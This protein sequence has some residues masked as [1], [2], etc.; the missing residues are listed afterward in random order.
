[1]LYHILPYRLLHI[2]Y[3]LFHLRHC[4]C[5]FQLRKYPL[6]VQ[7]L[8]LSVLLSILSSSTLV[9]V[10]FGCTTSSSPYHTKT[11]VKAHS[12]D[13]NGRSQDKHASNVIYNHFSFDNIY[14]PQGNNICS[15]SSA[16]VFLFS[17]I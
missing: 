8:N 15:A 13:C 4:H 12:E 9:F 5:H 16:V 3:F 7:I 6:S 2:R 1:M 17:L 10:A 14:G 11:L